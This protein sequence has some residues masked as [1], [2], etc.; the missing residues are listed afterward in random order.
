MDRLPDLFVDFLQLTRIRC[1]LVSRRRPS[2]NINLALVINFP[3]DYFDDRFQRR[4]PVLILL[5]RCLVIHL[6][7]ERPWIL[8]IFDSLGGV[9]LH[10]LVQLPDIILVSVEFFIWEQH[11]LLKVI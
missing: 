4:R 1:L 6:D 3:P 7:G 9:D 8:I 11:S 10:E 2:H 5:L